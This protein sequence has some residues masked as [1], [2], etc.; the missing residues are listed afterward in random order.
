[1]MRIILLT[2]ALVVALH[3]EQIDEGAPQH[4]VEKRIRQE[5]MAQEHAQ[6]LPTGDAWYEEAMEPVS[7]WAAEACHHIMTSKVNKSPGDPCASFVHDHAKDFREAG[8]RVMNHRAAN[9]PDI[10]EAGAEHLCMEVAAIL[11]E[12]LDE[13]EMMHMS[14]KEEGTMLSFCKDRFSLEAEY[15]HSWFA[16]L[17]NFYILGKRYVDQDKSEL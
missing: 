5:K 14:T 17:K 6:D 8:D 10:P 12:K 4:E 16:S 13:K 1:M 15:D 11:E 2:C 3:A 7:V 9:V